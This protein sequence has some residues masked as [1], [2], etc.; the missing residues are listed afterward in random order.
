MIIV[1]NDYKITLK[2]FL[3]FITGLFFIW[4]FSR[5][6]SILL[7]LLFVMIKSNIGILTLPRIQATEKSKTVNLDFIIAFKSG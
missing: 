3:F 2:T 4:L 7:L 1:N 5:T 6:S